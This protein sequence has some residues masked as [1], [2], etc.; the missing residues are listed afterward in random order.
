[1]TT[2]LP[3]A[4]N[5]YQGVLIQDMYGT[6]IASFFPEKGFHFQKRIIELEDKKII[7][8]KCENNILMVIAYDKSINKHE[9]M[10]FVFSE[11][12]EDYTLRSQI[13]VNSA[14]LNFIVLKKHFCVSM[15]EDESLVLFRT[16]RNTPSVRK[17]KDPALTYDMR[18]YHDQSK[19]KV[20][21]G[22]S[23]YEMTL[24]N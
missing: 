16:E 1:M 10:V 8:A 7:E 24:N 19:V 3:H 18:L 23:F 5:I 4:T 15:T 11:N 17:I 12:Y 21:I 14:G 20:A 9:R 22:R 6:K 13:D 2:V